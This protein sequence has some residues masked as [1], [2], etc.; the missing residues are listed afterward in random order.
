MNFVFIAVV[1]ACIAAVMGDEA[2][3]ISCSFSASIR[4][5]VVLPDGSVQIT[6]YE[7][8]SVAKRKFLQS[9][10]VADWFPRN[11]TA[12]FVNPNKYT[13]IQPFFDRKICAT[14]PFRSIIP[15]F[16]MSP[17]STK[18]ASHVPCPTDP[19]LMCDTW[20]YQDIEVW[21][22]RSDTDPVV[23]DEII[24]KDPQLN[25]KAVSFFRKFDPTEPDPSVFVIPAD[26]PC[27]NLI[28]D[29]SNPVAK[30]AVEQP[31]RP[32][33]ALL[34]FVFYPD[35]PYSKEAMAKAAKTAARNH[36]HQQHPHHHHHH[37]SHHVPP[38][39][40]PSSLEAR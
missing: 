39:S 36:G 15:C 12:L 37:H 1:F 28:N 7:H 26:Q 30:D 40:T 11:M 16:E 8:Y 23:L 20:Q 27:A 3:I 13:Y 19:S 38:K 33:D 10:L 14:I 32:I 17:N 4:S 2:P 21:F 31:Q 29:E 24:I 5:H 22:V 18:T 9:G 35:S 25:M 6:D 34:P